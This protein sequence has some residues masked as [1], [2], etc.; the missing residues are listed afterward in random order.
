MNALD[1]SQINRLPIQGFTIS[2]QSHQPSPLDQKLRETILLII[3]AFFTAN[4]DILLYICETG[5]GRQ[6]FR[7]RLF[8]RWFN[9]Y[10]NRDAY[11]MQTA[12]VQEGKTKNF[13]AL[14]VQKSNPRLNEIIAEFDETISILTNKPD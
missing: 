4:P 11:V 14:I 5:D 13:A 7:S 3:E 1:L 2:N 9:T 6:A 8:I 10:R 12:E